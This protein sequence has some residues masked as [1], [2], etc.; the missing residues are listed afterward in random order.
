MASCFANLAACGQAQTARAAHTATCHL[1]QA[2]PHV[3]RA[4]PARQCAKRAA[5]EGKQRR[6]IRPRRSET[7]RC[8]AIDEVPDFGDEDLGDDDEA[9]LGEEEDVDED[10]AGAVSDADADEDESDDDR[11]I[12][13]DDDQDQGDAEDDDLGIAGLS[14]VDLEEGGDDMALESREAQGIAAGD[15]SDE[16]ALSD[17]DLDDGDLDAIIG[18]ADTEAL[19]DYML[20]RQS[21][22]E[23]SATEDSQAESDEE[24][25][26][27]YPEPKERQYKLSDLM[28]AAGYNINHKDIDSVTISRGDLYLALPEVIDRL[29]MPYDGQNYAWHALSRG[30]VAI[31]AQ[32]DYPVDPELQ[33]HVPVLTVPCMAEA[34]HMLA[35]TFYERPSKR[36]TT[37]G[38]TGTR[39]KT[40]TCWLIRGILE[41]VPQLTGM[42]GSIEYALAHDKLS[43][44]GDLWV[45]DEEDPTLKRECSTPFHLAPYQGKYNVPD[46]TPDALAMQKL[47]AGMADRDAASCVIEAEPYSIAAER[48][49]EVDF[50]VAVFTNV[51]EDKMEGFDNLEDYLKAIG[52]LFLRLDDPTR[53]R[54]VINIDD[55]YSDDIRVYP[56]R[57]KVRVV[58]YS[59]SNRT[60]DVH[61][62]RAKCD[63]WET[64][65]E[66]MTPWGEMELYSFVIGRHNIP[67][68]LAAVATAF[69]LS[70]DSDQMGL[71]GGLPIGI[72]E[73]ADGIEA[74]VIVPGRCETIDE[75]QNFG[76]VVDAANDPQSLSRLLDSMRECIG[77]TRAARIFL[78]FGCD[79]GDDAWARPHM[80]EVAHYKADFVILTSSSPRNEQPDHIIYDIVAGFPDHILEENAK[81]PFPPG[82]LQDPGRV[83]AEALEFLWHH[84][85][86]YRRYVCEDRWTAI[87]WAIAT[88]RDK[89]IVIIAGRG[90]RDYQEW[91]ADDRIYRGWIDDRVEARNAL[92]KLR[93]L[94]PALRAMER[95]DLPWIEEG[96]RDV[97]TYNPDAEFMRP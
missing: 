88:A 84:C 7:L 32:D 57:A 72:Q 25:Q 42:V 77:E 85:W 36:M 38:V 3:Y 58:T 5:R 30:A 52:S 19:D 22:A 33:E 44:D 93:A 75:G 65:L 29:G 54:A 13:D 34:T 92:S 15:E 50:D 23:A 94:V 2:H 59:M 78:I 16:E 71:G 35:A 26:Q 62:L 28:A 20:S 12:E 67:N 63:P 55:P 1:L 9:G 37:V 8:R 97:R 6:V 18:A 89:D 24:L 39:G 80:G 81:M 56:E 40:T 61:M 53:H 41:A 60:A 74:T 4:S 51:S 31:V 96:E 64:V 11:V 90:N 48:C 76:V 21:D 82:F 47:L 79:G 43:E 27:T 17:A 73:V 86:E 68:I 69:A 45:P 70:K 83:P 66:I 95:H 91:H 87:R 10:D 14:G 46:A 49:S